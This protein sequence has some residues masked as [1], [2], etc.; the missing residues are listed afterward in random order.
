MPRISERQCLFRQFDNILKVMCK[1]GAEN[2]K[3]F[4]EI[5]EIR[6]Q[7]EGSRYLNE[8]NERIQRSKSIRKLLCF[9][10]VIKN[11]EILPACRKEIFQELI[12]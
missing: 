1:F 2:S 10:T 6:G 11:S 3:D 12:C 7:L 5:Y 9:T 4:G 8:R